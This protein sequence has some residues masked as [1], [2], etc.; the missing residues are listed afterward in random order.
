[1]IISI[2]NLT[3]GRIPDEEVQRVIRAINIQI[4]EDFEPA[5]SFGARLRLEGNSSNHPRKQSIADMRGDAIIYLWDKTNMP[6]A[7]GYHDSN[8][9]G[10]P[11]SFVF[12]ELSKRLGESWTVTL[13]HEALE[14][15]GDPQANLLVQGPHPEHAEQVVFHWFEM[16]DAVQAD[17]YEVDGVAVSNFVLPLYFTGGEQA[18]G[19]NDFLGRINGG[20]KL[21]SFGINPGGYVGFFDPASGKHETVARAGDKLAARRLE[22]KGKVGSGRGNLRKAEF[23]RLAD[24]AAPS[25]AKTPAPA[26]SAKPRRR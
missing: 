3:E 26:K 25:A 9:K 5:W 12:T 21:A 18:G 6:G 19:R 14:L 24:A 1:M 7:L 16:C 2:I 4:A 11:Y 13:S 15:V 20:R 10:I 22:A 23:A 17:S 8:N